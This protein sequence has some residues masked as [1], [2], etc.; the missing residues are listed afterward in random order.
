MIRYISEDPW[1]LDSTIGEVMNKHLI[2]GPKG[3]SEL[4]FPETLNVP[5]G[6]CYVS[7]LKNRKKMI[8]LMTT[9]ALPTVQAVV[10]PSCPVE[11]T[12]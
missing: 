1:R 12:R 7:R 4:C 10:K 5:R 11:M 2:T 9:V 8:C 6:E 3:N